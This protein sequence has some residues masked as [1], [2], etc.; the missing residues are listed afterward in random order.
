MGPIAARGAAAIIANVEQVLALEALAAAQGVDFRL[1]DGLR[2]G[3]GVAKAHAMVRSA[4]AHVDADRD[5]Q[6]DLAAGLDLV[7]SGRLAALVT[8]A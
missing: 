4:V 2:P 3:A 5:P 1:R 6:P 8:A 7:R